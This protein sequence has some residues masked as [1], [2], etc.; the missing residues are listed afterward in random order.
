MP[1]PLGTGDTAASTARAPGPLDTWPLPLTAAASPLTPGVPGLLHTPPPDPALELSPSFTN[2]TE[3]LDFTAGF[4]TDMLASR[5]SGAAVGTAGDCPSECVPCPLTCEPWCYQ[6]D[7][8]V[9]YGG[10]GCYDD[11]AWQQNHC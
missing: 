2:A 11:C 6:G 4:P 7:G 3:S 5:L 10:Y 8:C 9:D 1:S